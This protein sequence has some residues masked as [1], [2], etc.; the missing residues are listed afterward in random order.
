MQKLKLFVLA[1]LALGLPVIVLAQDQA[2]TPDS[3]GAAAIAALVPVVVMV[4]V[5]GVRLVVPKIP[6]ILL[7]IIATGFGAL[8]SFI[9]TVPVDGSLLKGAALGALAV[10][11]REVLNAMGVNVSVKKV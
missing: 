1:L 10:F 5:W 8:S 9:A 6:P 2:P 7:P 11:V 3:V 4:L